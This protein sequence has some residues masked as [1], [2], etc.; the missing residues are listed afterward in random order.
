[1]ERFADGREAVEIKAGE[2]KKRMENCARQTT[3]R[4]PSTR[5][6]T[7]SSKSSADEPVT[8]VKKTANRNQKGMY[9]NLHDALGITHVLHQGSKLAMVC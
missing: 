4:G 7:A 2:R 5:Q 8:K 1:M 3:S 6:S 9:Y